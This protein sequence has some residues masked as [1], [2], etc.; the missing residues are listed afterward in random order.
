MSHNSMTPQSSGSSPCSVWLTDEHSSN[1]VSRMRSRVIDKHCS[2]LMPIAIGGGPSYLTVQMPPCS[3]RTCNTCKMHC[4]SPISMTTEISS[5]EPWLL[6]PKLVKR[7]LILCP[8][9]MQ[10]CAKAH[11]NRAAIVANGWAQHVQVGVHC[12]QRGGGVL[13]SH[14]LHAFQRLAKGALQHECT[15]RFRQSEFT[16]ICH[17]QKCVAMRLLASVVQTLGFA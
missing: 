6:R 7:C 2:T 5:H 11:R 17:L 13:R 8:L 16:R 9:M 1:G 3:A 14:L 12:G 10:I 15:Y 4:Q